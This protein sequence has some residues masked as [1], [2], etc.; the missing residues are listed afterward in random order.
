MVHTS[1]RPIMPHWI[2][3]GEFLLSKREVVD[4]DDDMMCVRVEDGRLFVKADDS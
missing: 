3:C 2:D 1:P 4:D